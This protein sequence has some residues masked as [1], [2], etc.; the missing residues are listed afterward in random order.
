MIDQTAPHMYRL[1]ASC[2]SMPSCLAR[3][4]AM[5]QP[6]TSDVPSITP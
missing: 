5:N 1:P 6:T 3:R 2:W 4:I